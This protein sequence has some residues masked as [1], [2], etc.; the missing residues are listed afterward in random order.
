MDISANNRIY[1]PIVMLAATAMLIGTAWIGDDAFITLRVIDNFINGFGLRY[2]VIERVQVFTHPLWLLSLTPFYAL[3]KEAMV[4][5]MLVSV[6]MTLGALWLM[7]T[8]VAQHREYACML[9]LIAMISPTISSFSTSGLESPLTFLL[10]TL[11]VWQS[12]RTERIWIPAG[13]GGL[14]LLN[15]L[16]LFILLGPALV[17]LLFYAHGKERIKVAL[18]AMYPAIWTRLAQQ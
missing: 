18:S 14:L 5:T 3:T 13:I 4:T 16:D 2:N 9:V 1:L 15:R 10:L 8:K 11:F 17:Y 7:V 6:F 12:S